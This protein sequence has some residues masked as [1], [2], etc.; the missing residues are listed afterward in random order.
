MVNPIPLLNGVLRFS[1]QKLSK[2]VGTEVSEKRESVTYAPRVAGTKSMPASRHISASEHDEL[3]GHLQGL[4][5][6]GERAS[7]GPVPVSTSIL[8]QGSS[9]YAMMKEL[10]MLA[11]I[12]LA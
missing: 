9:R 1:T 7:P 6:A 3:A 5:M 8:A 12:M 11:P 2:A 10:A 4:W